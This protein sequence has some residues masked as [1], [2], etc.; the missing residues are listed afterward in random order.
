[1]RP[2]ILGALIVGLGLIALAYFFAPTKQNGTVPELALQNDMPDPSQEVVA[3]QAQIRKQIDIT[4]ANGDGIPDWKEQFVH[5]E[6]PSGLNEI[7]AE[8]YTPP[9][10]LTGQVSIEIFKDA[11]ELKSGGDFYTD[12][13]AVVT[14]TIED[15]T[16]NAQDRIYV[17][18]DITVT[19]AGSLTEEDER[20]YFNKV[21]SIIARNAI[22]IRNEAEILQEA[23]DSND[24]SLLTEL[25]QNEAYY[26]ALRDELLRLP[27]PSLYVKEHLDLINATN[28]IYNDI[29]GM[30]LVFKDPLAALLRVK[31]YQDDAVG[32]FYSLQNFYFV[33]EESPVEF[34]DDDLATL[35]EEFKPSES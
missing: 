35:F 34:S 24:P 29:L 26:K 27:A 32:L 25:Q 20:T 16:Q 9:E 5:I 22:D 21:A 7:D 17:A 2:K 1:M 23:L 33:I 11:I 31:R 8:N 6:N 10:T 30:Q 13:P 4:D 3:T 28:A 14:D 19:P 18:R 12:G 15:I